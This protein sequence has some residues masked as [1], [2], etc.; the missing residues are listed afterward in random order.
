[1]E[2]RVAKKIQDDEYAQL[3]GVV[4]PRILVT[5]S[6]DPSSRL[7]TFSKGQ[8][9]GKTVFQAY[10]DILPLRNPLTA[11]YVRTIEQRQVS[12]VLNACEAYTDFVRPFQEI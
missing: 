2:G 1:V 5:T 3:S 7:G 6:R 4:D 12:T 9:S 11:T 8:K 10:T